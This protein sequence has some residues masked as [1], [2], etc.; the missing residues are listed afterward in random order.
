MISISGLPKIPP[1][2]LCVTSPV[3][4][5]TTCSSVPINAA[6]VASSTD[7]IVIFNESHIALTKSKAELPVILTHISFIV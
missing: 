3:S 7:L 4:G 5:S 2:A 1:F 6:S